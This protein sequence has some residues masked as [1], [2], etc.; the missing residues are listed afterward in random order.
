MKKL[1]IFILMILVL[2]ACSGNSQSKLKRYGV[3]SGMVQYKITTSGNVMGGTISG[4]GTA[5]LY[6]KDWG[7]VELKEE[8][9]TKTTSMKLFGRSKVDKQSTHTMDKLDNGKSYS[10]DFNEK[11]IYVKNDPMM[12]MMKES[13]TDAGEAGKKMLESMGGKKIGNEK[14]MG[15][16]C[17]VW[18][19]PGGKEW[20][21]KGVVLKVDVQMMGV[22]TVK[23]ATDVK[24]DVSVPGSKF[25]L[26][27]FPIKKLDEM[28]GGQ[29]F[30]N[31]MSGEDNVD[32]ATKAEYLKKMQNMSFEEW[33]K[34]VTEDDPEMK[35]LSDEEL[36]Q[37]Y[38]MMQQMLKMASPK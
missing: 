9:S 13:G 3:K 8:K 31:G 35:K 18:S 5:S 6:F 30:D 29:N 25:E 2:S 15:Y 27:D 28:M 32:A 10:V 38:D 17:E 12:E 16:D 21:Y 11:V 34:M 36:R 23:E 14:Y 4:S 33:K 7:A 1:H 20:I 24:F 19:I 37:Q 26:P 22:R